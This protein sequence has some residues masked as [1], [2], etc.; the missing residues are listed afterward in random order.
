MRRRPSHAARRLRIAVE[1]LP[2][3]TKEAMLRG[4]DTNRIIVGAYVDPRS[5]GI[6]PMLAAH[7]NGGRTSVA[8]FARA[9]DEYTNARRPRRATRREVRYL[10]ALL[11]ES[12]DMDPV[13]ERTSIAEL[14]AQLRAERAQ[15]SGC[16]AEPVVVEP[17]EPEEPIHIRH[18]VPTGERHRAAELR[19][20]PNWAWLRPTRRYD[21][22]KDLL[23][24]AEEQL[25]EQR[26]AEL[27][28][29]P[30]RLRS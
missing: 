17:P 14:A 9:W 7:R 21:E 4:I 5:G 10:R 30:E 19:R 23:A 16:P 18:R 20:R 8:S 12:L 24:A 22:Y 27:L 26:A 13:L 3:H 25:S 6:C 11:L 2:Q 29:S 1:R 28:D 15:L